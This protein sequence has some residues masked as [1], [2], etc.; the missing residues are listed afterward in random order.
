MP[1]TA[2]EDLQAIALQDDEDYIIEKIIE[3]RGT[4]NARKES[5]WFGV[6]YKNF[7]EDTHWLS[8][9]EVK[10]TEAFVNFCIERNKMT[11]IGEHAKIIFKDRIS[12]FL[13]DQAI[14]Y[15]EFQLKTQ[16]EAQEKAERK[17]VRIEEEEI[18]K[19]KKK[20]KESQQRLELKEAKS[21]VQKLTSELSRTNKKRKAD[22][23]ITEDSM[24]GKKSSRTKKPNQFFTEES[25]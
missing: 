15:A 4:Q 17:K 8:Y 16:K 7:N 13:G 19:N 12:E 1:D 23:E 22:K 3:E 6:T 9:L 11:W 14:K 2:E 25:V 21:A 5:Y 18:R 10:N 20:E 24:P